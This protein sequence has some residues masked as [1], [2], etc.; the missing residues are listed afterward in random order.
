MGENARMTMKTIALCLLLLAGA[1]LAA[2]PPVVRNPWTTNTAAVGTAGQVTASDGVTAV[3]VDFPYRAFGALMSATP[4]VLNLNPLNTHFT[5]TNYTT[6]TGTNFTASKEEGTETN[7]IAGYYLV[8]IAVSIDSVGNANHIHGHVATNGVH[9]TEIGYETDNTTGG[10]TT[11][12]GSSAGI[13]YLPA[14]TRIEQ[15]ISNSG[16]TGFVTNIQAT[17]LVAPP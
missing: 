11:T 13:L 15:Q 9:V 8:S 16:S 1:A 10:L 5:I 7:S 4:S 12:G 2:P 6:F 3:W 17:L 14:G